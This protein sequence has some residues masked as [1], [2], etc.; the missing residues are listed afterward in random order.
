M[1][2]AVIFHVINISFKF[3]PDHDV[4]RSR[5]AG[6]DREESVNEEYAHSAKKAY[7]QYI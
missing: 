4:G 2:T 7:R 1:V 3:Y 5:P 6:V